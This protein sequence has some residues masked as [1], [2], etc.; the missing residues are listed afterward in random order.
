[1]DFGKRLMVRRKC[2]SQQRLSGLLQRFGVVTNVLLQMQLISACPSVLH[3]A[4]GQ[5]WDRAVAVAAGLQPCP[6]L[7]GC[8]RL[9]TL[10]LPGSLEHPTGSRAAAV[11][12]A[13]QG[14]SG[15]HNPCYVTITPQ[16]PGKPSQEFVGLQ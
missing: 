11:A 15:T 5:L 1:M 12:L 3:P 2:H 9:G 4:W 10:A 16:M 14:S 13:G 6:E 7:Q 8:P